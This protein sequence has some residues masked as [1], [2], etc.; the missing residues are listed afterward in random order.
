MVVNL[1]KLITVVLIISAIFAGFFV[2]LS[3]LADEDSYDIDITEDAYMNSS[4]NK[5]DTLSEQLNPQYDSVKEI[6]TKGTLSFFSGLY[7]AFQIGKSIVTIPFTL[8]NDL[9]NIFEEKL[10][11]PNWLTTLVV[12]LITISAIFALI[13]ILIKWRA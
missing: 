7:D 9:W 12:I 1:Q 8:L 5:L 13:A 3:D 10:G 6:K 4:L 2:F 11:I